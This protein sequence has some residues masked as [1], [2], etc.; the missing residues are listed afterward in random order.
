MFV[1]IKADSMEKKR[2]F[3]IIYKKKKKKE[4]YSS[5]SVFVSEIKHK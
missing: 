4:K 1:K 5:C 2:I 3:K